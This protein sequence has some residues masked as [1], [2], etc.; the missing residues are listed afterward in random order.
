MNRPFPIAMLVYWRVTNVTREIPGGRRREFF[1]AKWLKDMPW[2]RHTERF[3]KTH[4][5]SQ[6]NPK[7]TLK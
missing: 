1:W 6:G 5:K 4:G 7:P 2:G 3:G